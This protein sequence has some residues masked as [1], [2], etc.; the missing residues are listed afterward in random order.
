VPPLADDPARLV[1]AL[2]DGPL[3]NSWKAGA[4]YRPGCLPCQT[5]PGVGR[6]RWSGLLT[7]ARD[8]VNRRAR[9]PAHMEERARP[10]VACRPIARN[11]RKPGN[12][13]YGTGE[14]SSLGNPC[15]GLCSS[16]FSARRSCCDD[17]P[18]RPDQRPARLPGSR[19]WLDQP[20]R[21]TFGLED[22]A[23]IAV[24]IS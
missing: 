1:G 22:V 6:E 14:I 10:T 19:P 8:R 9:R 18:R 2:H 17:Q 11:S 20:G 5:S 12:A 15:G 4:L 7:R 16:C 23:R 3:A 21:F 13:S 24:E